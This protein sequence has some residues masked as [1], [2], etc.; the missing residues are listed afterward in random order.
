MNLSKE[1]FQ[2]KYVFLSFQVDVFQMCVLE[3]ENREPG[4]QLYHLEHYI[5]GQYIKFNS[6]SGFVD[7]NARF[8]PQVFYNQQTVLEAERSLSF[9]PC[10]RI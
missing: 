6:N 7:E 1:E 10:I 4:D 3:F 9:W 5:E 8:T 2:G